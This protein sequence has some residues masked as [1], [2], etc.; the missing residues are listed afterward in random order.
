MNDLLCLVALA[1]VVFLAVAMW[2]TPLPLD[3]STHR[4]IADIKG[5][6][7]VTTDEYAALMRDAHCMQ[8]G[9]AMDL[10]FLDEP[11]VDVQ[12]N[13]PGYRT[14]DLP[15]APALVATLGPAI[16]NASEGAR[17]RTPRF[18]RRFAVTRHTYAKATPR[19]AELMMA[20]A[21]KL[22][23]GVPGALPY[24]KE[25]VAH[26]FT[27]PDAPGRMPAPSLVLRVPG[28]GALADEVVVHG[29]HYDSINAS[30]RGGR[31][32]GADDNLASC[33]NVLEHF[34]MYI[35]Y[36]ARLAPSQ[37]R[38]VEFHLYSGEEQ[39]LKGSLAIAAS[40]KASKRKVVAVY[41]ND[42]IGSMRQAKNAKGRW[43]AFYPRGPKD[44]HDNALTNF[45][46]AC[47]RAYTSLRPVDGACGY[48]CTDSSAWGRLGFASVDASA[49]TPQRGV[50]N[51]AMHT[52]KDVVAG[53]NFPYILEHLKAAAA[54]VGEL[55]FAD[56]SAQ[57]EGG[58]EVVEEEE[59]TED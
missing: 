44:G 28:A 5:T 54:T 43:P 14:I 21:D 45:A 29:A 7:V 24:A 15:S 2:L 53:L 49:Y 48:A 33:N 9:R 39:G 20:Y 37:R 19:I 18:C 55:A 46:Q 4:I 11:F 50:V 30:K 12:E 32:P 8:P 26:R 6:R 16:Q 56:G 58:D 13:G 38:T 57:A 47:A 31:A 27:E 35:G 10:T 23:A 51:P 40:Y 1:L 36:A 22:A 3:P 25:T 34:A 41:N 52:A 17:R 59:E 42:V